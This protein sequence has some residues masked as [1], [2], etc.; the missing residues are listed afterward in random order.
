MSPSTKTGDAK[1]PRVFGNREGLR[2]G[3]VEVAPWAPPS[4]AE[5]SAREPLPLPPPRPELAPAKDRPGPASPA[6]PEA[7]APEPEEAR[8]RPS[9]PA[10]IE[11]DSVHARVW[12]RPEVAARAARSILVHPAGPEST[13]TPAQRLG[14]LFVALGQE[15]AGEVMK[16]MS[17]YEIEESAQAVAQLQSATAEMRQQ[18]LEAFERDLSTGRWVDR[19]G[20]DVARGALERAVGPR[21]AREILDR[22]VGQSGGFLAM[23]KA[24]PE[25]VA[26]H[27][28]REHPQTIALILSQ[29]EPAQA[30]GIL[31]RFSDRLMADVSYRLATLD[32]VTPAAL[33]ELDKALEA[34]LRD[35]IFRSGDQEVGGPKVLADILNLCGTSAEKNILDQFDAQDP[36]VAEWVRSRMF[37]FDD[38]EGLADA[39]LAALLAAVDE[40]DLASACKAVPESLMSRIQRLVPEPRWKSL[41]AEME[42]LGPIRTSSAEEAQLRIVARVLELEEQGTLTVVRG[43]DR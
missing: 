26:P 40:T 10:W 41:A 36:E 18:V 8:P 12:A 37:V 7:E 24:S 34:Q 6:R 25:Q 2:R 39:D 20:A 11:A 14:T 1:D 23:R 29:L 9:P 13:L 33:K 4:T 32:K 43:Q 35:F 16:F 22:V 21:K 27:L 30:A 5:V 17:D 19:G 28:S 3:D 38:L 15:V 42:R 31:Q